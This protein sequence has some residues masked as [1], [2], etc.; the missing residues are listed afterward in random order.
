MRT[1]QDHLF[2]ALVTF[3]FLMAVALLLSYS[4]A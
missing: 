1:I 3:W 2:A 4:P